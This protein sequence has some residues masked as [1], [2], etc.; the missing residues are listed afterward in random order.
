MELALGCDPE[1]FL[2]PFHEPGRENSK[3]ELAV[4][5]LEKEN[6]NA[7]EFAVSCDSKI[8]SLEMLAFW[9]QPRFRSAWG[10]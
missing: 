9:L 3:V 7:D 4:S 1:T 2:Q 10:D 8:C 5:E 6:I